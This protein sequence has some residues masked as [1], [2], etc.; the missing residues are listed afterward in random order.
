MSRRFAQKV[1]V[2]TGVNDRGIGAAIAERIAEEG[3]A[4]AAL[5][6]DGRPNRTLKRLAKKGEPVLDVHCDIT[7]EESVQAAV[8]AVM[9]EFGQID[10]LVN[11]AGAERAGLLEEQSDADWSLMVD[12]NLTGTMRMTRACLR[13]LAEPGGAV[14]NLSSALAVGGAAGFGAYAAS[15]AGIIGMTQSLAVEVAGKG[16]RAVCVAPAL[17]HTPMLHEHIKTSTPEDMKRMEEA[18]VIGTGIVQDVAAAVAFLASDEARWVTGVTLPMGYLNQFK[19]PY[20][21]LSGQAADV[22]GDNALF[23]H[24]HAGRAEEAKELVAAP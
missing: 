3:G 16:Q 2:V 9:G 8:D 20:E 15:K 1:A 21:A 11:N 5:H 12:V 19:L 6:F 23:P 22:S 18:H 24:L 17:V 13:Y 4:V 10:V 7:S 14:V